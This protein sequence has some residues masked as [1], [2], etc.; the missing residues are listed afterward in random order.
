MSGEGEAMPST[1]IIP[2]IGETIS[3][4]NTTTR[5]KVWYIDL[6]FTIGKEKK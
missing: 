2:W 4:H 1:I 3:N 5:I 6:D